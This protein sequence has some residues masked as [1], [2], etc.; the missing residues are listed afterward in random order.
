MKKKI[1]Y[2]MHVDWHWIKQR[3]HF[4][5]EGL[6][7]L[8]EVDVGYVPAKKNVK[9]N[10]PNS[11][12]HSALKLRKLIKVPF[13]GRSRTAR[14]FQ[15]Y[16]NGVACN[17]AA[18]DIVWICAPEILYRINIEK[19]K[20]KI[21]I[22]DCMDDMIESHAV[23]QYKK[24]LMAMEKEVIQMADIIF[25]SSDSLYNKML[26]RGA[27]KEQLAT[28]YNATSLNSL[29]AK[30]GEADRERDFFTITYFGTISNWIDIEIIQKLLNDNDLKNLRVKMIGPSEI[31]LPIHERLV[32]IGPVRHEDLSSHVTDN[33]L[34]ILPFILNPI[35]ISV[36]PV[37]LYEYIAFHGNIAARFYPEIERYSEFVNF[38]NNYEELK[39]IVTRLMRD[40]ALKYS[41]DKA[42]EFLASNTWEN[43][44]SK[45]IEQIR[46]VSA[47]MEEPTC[48]H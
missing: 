10:L 44:V 46:N 20:G 13:S 22:Y 26:A 33:D 35:T 12:T 24:E 1:L 8:Y 17:L 42:E 15:K 3:P 36:D 47:V 6:S 21:I 25:V 29:R 45:I 37:K 31:S 43:R 27:S 28:I 18:Y 19:A 11:N 9:R 14:C 7:A 48:S 34:F 32:H 5:A 4:L 38:Y 2:L 30:V 16:I 40:N 39:E 23:P 41:P